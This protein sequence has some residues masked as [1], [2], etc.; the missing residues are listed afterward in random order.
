MPVDSCGVCLFVPDRYTAVSVFLQYWLLLVVSRYATL[1]WPLDWPL[2]WPDGTVCP[3]K[4][5]DVFPYTK[6]NAQKSRNLQ[7][8]TLVRFQRCIGKCTA[9]FACRCRNVS[10][11]QNRT[12][13][14]VQNHY[15][16]RWRDILLNFIVMPAAQKCLAQMK[17]VNIY[18]FRFH[19]MLK[20]AYVYYVRFVLINLQ[21][22]GQPWRWPVSC[23]PPMLIRV[24]MFGCIITGSLCL[25]V[26][27]LSCVAAC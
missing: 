21:H 10:N 8:K 22:C 4:D 11:W 27:V 14:T 1:Y 18:Q 2:C 24:V 20:Y 7:T 6:S 19:P 5:W 3:A 26:S 17:F 23:L 9:L 12:K 15:Q 25:I 13:T 16:Y